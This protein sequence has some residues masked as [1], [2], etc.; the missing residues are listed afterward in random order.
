M[1]YKNQFFEGSSWFKLNNLGLAQGVPLELD[2]IVAKELKLKVRNR[3]WEL[4]SAFL[5]VT[6]EILERVPFCLFP[7]LNNNFGP[8]S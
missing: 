7:L 2:V 1:G 3:F 5:K 8:E 4:I 6:E